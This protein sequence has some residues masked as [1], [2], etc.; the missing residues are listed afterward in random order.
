M[1]WHTQNHKRS[2][3]TYQNW[4]N[5]WSLVSLTLSEWDN[6]KIIFG[7]ATYRLTLSVAEKKLLLLDKQIGGR[8][9]QQL[10]GYFATLTNGQAGFRLRAPC[11]PCLELHIVLFWRM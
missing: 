6:W 7:L 5:G 1:R 8:L 11:A 3:M 2:P 9:P 10:E 4:I